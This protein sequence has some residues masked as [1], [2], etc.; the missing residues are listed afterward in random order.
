MWL[1]A[2][3]WCSTQVV[4]ISKMF[5]DKTGTITPREAVKMSFV[6]QVWFSVLFVLIVPVA[7]RATCTNVSCAERQRREKWT[8]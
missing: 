1:I 4:M 7:H 2:L 6:L 8:K 3:T 5:M